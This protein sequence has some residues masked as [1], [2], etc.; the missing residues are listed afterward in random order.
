MALKI[1]LV[2]SKYP[3]EYSGSGLRAH[4]TYQRLEKKFGIS[5]DVLCSSIEINQSAV[6]EHEGIK[7]TRIAAKII[8]QQRSRERNKTLLDKIALRLNYFSEAIRVRAYLRKN[9]HDYDVVHV[10]GNVALTTEVVA[11]CQRFKKPLIYEFCNEVSSPIPYRPLLMKIWDPI[12]FPP[13]TQFVCISQRLEELCQ[14]YG[15]RQN[16]WTRPN[17]VDPRNFFVDRARK[18]ECR[19]SLTKFREEDLLLVYVANFIPRKNQLFLLDVLARL[20]QP[21]KLILAGPVVQAGPNVKGDHDYFHQVEQKVKQLHLQERVEIVER[22]IDHMED[23]IRMSDVYLFPTK[24]EG[25]GTPMLESICC[26]VPVVAHCIRGITDQWII[27]GKNG[28]LSSLDV[29]DFA[30]KIEQAV[31]I[32]EKALDQSARELIQVAGT[33]VIDQKYY[34]LLCSAVRKEDNVK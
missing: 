21:Y 6:Y 13:Q 2:S 5:W 17:P 4:R 33:D 12:A 16:I 30:N 7:V 29:Q 25:L 28:Y 24:A 1:L 8:A 20:P 23:F 19:R 27:D 15:L 31:K 10:F 22:F 14:R 32:P 26:G 3:P 11:C 34:E 18:A 9:I